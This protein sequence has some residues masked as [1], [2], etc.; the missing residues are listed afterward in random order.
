[1]IGR[2]AT[3][4]ATGI[5]IVTGGLMFLSWASGPLRVV[6]DVEVH[7]AGWALVAG[8]SAS[9]LGVLLLHPFFIVPWQASVERFRSLLP[10]VQGIRK[11]QFESSDEDSEAVTLMHDSAVHD[12]TAALHTLGVRLSSAFSPHDFPILLDMMER[13]ALREARKRFPIK[14]RSRWFGWGGRR[15]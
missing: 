2:M 5:T 14:R 3:G 1:M 12:A 9:V 11:R 4:V 6:G 10:R 13:G 7:P 8:I 15:H